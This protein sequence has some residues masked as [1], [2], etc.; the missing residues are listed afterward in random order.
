MAEEARE[1]NSVVPLL[2]E[3]RRPDVEPFN[4]PNVFEAGTAPVSPV[5]EVA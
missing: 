4:P 1:A 5:E 2:I 3:G